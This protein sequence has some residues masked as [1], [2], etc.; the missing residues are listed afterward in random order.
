MAEI[1]ST[2]LIQTIHQDVLAALL[3]FSDSAR[4]AFAQRVYPTSLV[5]IGVTVPNLRMVLKQL[6]IESKK[7]Q[8]IDQY[9][10][11]LSLVKDPHFE[12]R[13][14]G[15]GFVARQK[16]L[17]NSLTSK[18][19]LKLCHQPDNWILADTYGTLILGPKWCDH[20]ITFQHIQN[21]ANHP[22]LWEKRVGIVSIAGIYRKSNKFIPEPT[23][24]LEICEAC[25]NDH[26]DM[27]VKAV[28]WVLRS[29]AGFYPNEVLRFLENHEPMIHSRIL[30]EVRHKIKTTYKN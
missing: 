18:Q 1:S 21:F 17:L 4:Q 29:I 14:L 5:V 12:C 2:Q 3:Q 22:N 27:I 8:A 6:M 20:V 10:L 26:R 15:L 7:L 16:K 24:S 9:E 28:S 23:E 13:Q 30:R 25:I 19:T 11:A